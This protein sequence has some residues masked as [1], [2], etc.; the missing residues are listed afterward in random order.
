[1]ATPPDPTPRAR[2]RIPGGWL[3][4]GIIAL[5]LIVGIPTGILLTRNMSPNPP[6]PNHADLPLVEAGTEVWGHAMLFQD[7]AQ[8]MIC[9]LSMDS[10]PPQC[11]GPLVAGDFSWDDIKH[12]E[13]NGVRWTNEY[14]RVQG[15]YD[16]SAGEYGTLTL[17]TP[18][19]TRDGDDVNTPE[20]PQLCNDPLRGA[21]PDLTDHEAENALHAALEQ[22]EVIDVWVSNGRDAYNVVVRGDAE[23]VHATLRN[24]WGGELC[25]QSS[26]G[27]TQEERV[28]A[29]ERIIAALPRG[30]VIAG[31]P[32]GRGGG[33]GLEL[34]YLDAASY[35]A[36]REA[37]GDIPIVVRTALTPVGAAPSVGWN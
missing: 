24:V 33:V 10:Y 11:A 7:G 29:V 30:Q 27:A 34:L 19:T 2:S 21:N 16:P 13:A 36:I 35:D 6:K 5:A 9:F 17:T 3:A 31:G 15:T 26:A 14:Y 23:K 18:V 12:E 28:A 20:F 4:A 37:V 22:F 1:M 25:V 8:P 32:E